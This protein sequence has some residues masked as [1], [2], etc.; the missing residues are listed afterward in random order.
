MSARKLAPLAL[1]PALVGCG[2]Q[3]VTYT[4]VDKG[5]KALLLR[6]GDDE[7]ELSCGW[8]DTVLDALTRW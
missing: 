7:T 2:R 3:D 8:P 5:R 6:R 4:R 1:L